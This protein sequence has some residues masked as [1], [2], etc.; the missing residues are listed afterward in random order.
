[1][2]VLVA[3]PAVRPQIAGPRHPVA[4]LAPVRLVMLLLLMAAGVLVVL[5]RLLLLATMAPHAR[6]HGLVA[7]I[8]MRGDIT[9]R[10]G[11]PLA[12]T[13]EAWSIAIRPAE[14][15]NN[16]RELAEKLAILIPDHDA[17]WY[18]RV[19]TSG[20]SFVYL[21]RRAAPDLARA[22]NALGEPAMAY[23][24]EGERLYP[25]MRLASHVL[26]LV[27]ADGHGARGIEAMFN[28]RL[29]DPARRG[30]PVV[31]SI[32]ARVQAAM[33][34]EL[35]NAKADFQAQSAAGVVLDVRTGE[36]IAMVSLPDYDV[37]SPPKVL[38]VHDENDPGMTIL[39]NN[40]T[41]AVLEL[42]SAIKPITM[43][44]AM[45]A[46][47]ITSLGKRYDARAPIKIAGYPIRDDHPQRRWLNVP[48]TLVYSSNIVTARIAE[49]MGEARMKAMF[50]QFGFDARVPIELHERE[51]TSLRA[52]W[53]ISRVMT[54]GYGH[55]IATTPLHLAVA[56]S[57]TVNGGI[58]RPA[59]LLRVTPGREVS[60]RRV[61]SAQT[62][63]MIRKMLRLVVLDGTGKKGDVP[64]YQV[65]AKTG[66]AEVSTP[67]GYSKTRNITTFAAAFP[68]DA[69]RYVVIAMLHS[70]IP[71]AQSG[72]K[73]TA[74]WTVAPVV[75]RVIARTA[76]MLGVMP[77]LHRDI[78]VSALA[79]LIWHPPG[80]HQALV[81]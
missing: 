66:T 60:G 79:P 49:Q 59:T 6:D 70:P 23:E 30:A 73:A 29:S 14:V 47:V 28:D 55:G 15:I 20:K 25:Q 33:E 8:P 17:G 36:V 31:L 40:M 18:Y 77:D 2:T 48:E 3:R 56:F 4:A 81:E 51:K 22:V 58:L 67:H 45:D 38:N 57:A 43:A 41:Q 80:E 12:R 9:D 42:G 13:I 65:G 5:V 74:G 44:A 35:G 11:V 53:P 78:D 69:P 54:S 62:S 50:H 26:G 63:E 34:N 7:P 52:R 68:I 46:G 10:N 71:N 27:D 37:N 19:L 16:R 72:G 39:R 1:M 64:G 21:R 75:A 61:V 76:T 32:D 24:R